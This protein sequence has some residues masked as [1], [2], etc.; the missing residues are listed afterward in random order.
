MQTNI[1]NIVFDLG[2]VLLHWQPEKI[3]QNYTEDTHLQNQLLTNIFY[4][5]DWQLLDKGTITEQQALARFANNSGLSEADTKNLMA[6]IKRSLLPKEDS[7]LLLETLK[8]NHQIFCLSNICTEIFDYVSERHAF[9]QLF[10]DVIVSAQVKMIKPD[11][12]I[13]DYMLTRFSVKP[14]ETIFIDDMHANI[15]SAQSLGIHGIQFDHA[16]NCR[17][18]IE[19]IIG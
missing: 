2:A 15:T 12:E 14:E 6:L 5:E 13:F 11:P 9:F 16:V 1:R 18:A 3:V 8:R 7:V 4:H 10:D 17:A 19:K